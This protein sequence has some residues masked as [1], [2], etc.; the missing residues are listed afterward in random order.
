MQPPQDILVEQAPLEN[1]DSQRSLMD[2]IF[3][4]EEN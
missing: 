2:I 1:P 3:G 4:A